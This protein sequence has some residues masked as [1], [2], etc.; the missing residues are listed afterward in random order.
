[1]LFTCT[2]AI[3][4][5]GRVI[6]YPGELILESLGQMGEWFPILKKSTDVKMT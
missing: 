2:S 5:S 6:F 4:K 3:T 1:M